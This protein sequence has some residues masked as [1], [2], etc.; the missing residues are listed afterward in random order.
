MGKLFCCS[1]PQAPH[2]ITPV[3][4]MDND[5]SSVKGKLMP[6]IRV[7]EVPTPMPP[8]HAWPMP[9]PRGRALAG[10]SRAPSR[11]GAV[12]PGGSNSIC[13]PLSLFHQSPTGPP[14]LGLPDPEGMNT[15]GPRAGSQVDCIQQSLYPTVTAGQALPLSLSEPQFDQLSNGFKT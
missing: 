6:D 10:M 4:K 3:I 12:V 1:D 2:L 13:K 5:N 11:A 9:A 14:G 7:C 15:L 8:D